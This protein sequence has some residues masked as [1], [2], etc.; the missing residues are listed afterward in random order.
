VIYKEEGWNLWRD[1]GMRVEL[2]KRV[3]GGKESIE[4]EEVGRN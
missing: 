4:E 3:R 2:E 1:K